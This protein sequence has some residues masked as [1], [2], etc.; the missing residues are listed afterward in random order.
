MK[1]ERVASIVQG[2][3]HVY[4]RHDSHLLIHQPAVAHKILC[5]FPFPIFIPPFF[6]RGVPPA[7][8]ALRTL[9]ARSSRSAPHPAPSAHFHVTHETCFGARLFVRALSASGTLLGSQTKKVSNVINDEFGC[10]KG[11]GLGLGLGLGFCAGVEAAEAFE[12]YR[13]VRR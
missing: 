13:V 2:I 5:F 6:H 8:L 9:G 7:C 4:Q 12:V 3:I 11:L 10:K 1:V